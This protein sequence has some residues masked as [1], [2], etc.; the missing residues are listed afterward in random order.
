MVRKDVWWGLLWLGIALALVGGLPSSD[1]FLSGAEARG[2]GKNPSKAYANRV[3]RHKE[4][5]LE[6]E[7]RH[8]MRQAA[9]EKRQIG[10]LKRQL[11]PHHSPL[12]GPTPKR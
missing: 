11:H 6:R 9:R 10:Y 5:V 1:L 4:H 7:R 8:N 2:K 3:L 12:K